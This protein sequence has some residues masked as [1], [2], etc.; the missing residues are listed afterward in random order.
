MSSPL[1]QKQAEV[2]QKLREKLTGE[3]VGQ[4]HV[5]QAIL[6][7]LEYRGFH[8]AGKYL[9]ETISE[10]LFPELERYF[11]DSFKAGALAAIGQIE[12][13]MPKE[14]IAGGDH[15]HGWNVCREITLSLLTNLKQE[16]K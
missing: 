12:E 10:Y 8:D 7:A 9:D 1:Q 4:N 6:S 16:V 5:S 3:V 15:S 14:I 13:G 2:I 11:V